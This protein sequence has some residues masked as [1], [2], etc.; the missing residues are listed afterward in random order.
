MRNHLKIFAVLF[1]FLLAGVVGVGN[2]QAEDKQKFINDPIDCTGDGT[3]YY[4]PNCDH[5]NPAVREAST[6][7]SA[8]SGYA[9]TQ[10]QQQPPAQSR[11][12]AVTVPKEPKQQ[13]AADSGEAVDVEG[14]SSRDSIIAAAEQT[15]GFDW[16]ALFVGLGTVS[17]LVSILVVY[18][19]F[20][21]RTLSN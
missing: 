2:V 5:A 21:R 19:H 11:D 4:T 7:Q 1:A 16:N 13:V 15:Q 10:T 9:S 3:Q 14:A 17:V 8:G 12:Q 6:N 18:R 20:R